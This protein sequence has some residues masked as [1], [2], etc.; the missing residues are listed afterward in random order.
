MGQQGRALWGCMARQGHDNTMLHN[1]PQFLFH[2]LTPLYPNTAGAPGHQ[3]AHTRVTTSDIRFV[4]SGQSIRPKRLWSGLH[5]HV[6]VHVPTRKEHNGMVTPRH[7]GVDMIWG[8]KSSK[9]KIAWLETGWAYSALYG[10]W[11]SSILLLLKLQWP[12]SEVF[13]V[14]DT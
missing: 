14:V 2:S 8:P 7:P 10:F 4:S 9:V 12:P 3:V 1:T 6:P 11:C 13:C 5:V